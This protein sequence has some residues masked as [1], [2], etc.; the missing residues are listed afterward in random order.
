MNAQIMTHTNAAQEL[1]Q[2]IHCVIQ[3]LPEADRS[4][5][6]QRVVSLMQKMPDAQAN[7]EIMAILEPGFQALQGR[8]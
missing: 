4:G 6:H 2:T 1:A 7:T 5:S 3:H 8:A